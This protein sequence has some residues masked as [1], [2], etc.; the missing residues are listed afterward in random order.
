MKVA[1]WADRHARS[2]LFLLGA[3]VLGGIVGTFALPVS[4]LPRVNFPRIRVNLDAGERPAQR[5]E[6]EVTMPV[7]EAVRAIPGVRGVQSTTSRGSAEVWISFDWGQDMSTALLQAESQVNRVLPTLPSG[8]TFEIIRMDPTVFPVIAYSLTSDTRPLSQL[9]DLA[10]FQLR[11]I[12]SGVTGVAKIG[13]SGGAVEEY[14]VIVDPAKLQAHHLVVSDLSA[15][16][17]AANVLTAAGRVEDHFKLYLVVTDTRFKSLDEIGATVIRSGAGG[18]VLLSDVASVRQTVA[19]QFTRATSDGRD[20]VLMNV[21][22]Q[23]GGNTV[24]IARGIRN[25]LTI[26]QKRLPADVRISSWY[27]QSDLITASARSV[28][29]AVLIGV[30]LAAL[31]LLLFLRNLRITLI[32]AITVPIVLSITALL[33]YLLDQSFNIMT[34]G[35]MAAAV[36]LIID[37]AIVMSEHIVR[38]LHGS[39]ADAKNR[40]LDATDEFTRPLAGS[41]L[42]T[43]I[44]HIPPAFLIGVT[45]AFF[46]ALSLSM[47]ASLIISFLV[48]WLIIPV[49][50]ARVL[51]ATSG[52]APDAEIGKRAEQVDRENRARHRDESL[53]V[54]TGKQTEQVGAENLV[55]DRDQPLAA[56]AKSAEGVDPENRLRHRDKTRPSATSS[57]ASLMRPVLAHP[58]VV[59]LLILPLLA[60]G[61]LAFNRIPSGFMPEVDEGGFVLDYVGPP[62]TSLTETDRILR[63]VEVILR[64]TPEVQTYSRRTGFALGGDIM[65]ANTGDFFIRLKPFPRRPIA[66][67]MDD[68]RSQVEHSLPGL[69]VELAQLMEDLIGDLTGK[70]EPVVI[71]IYSDDEEQLAGL[72]PKVAEA[73]GKVPN[74]V[75]VRNGMVPAGDALNV[76]VDRIKASLEGVDPDSVTKSLTDLLSGSVTTQLQR[77]P[78]LIDLRVWIPKDMRTTIRDVGELNLRAADGHLFPLKRVAT[79]TAITGQPEIT[80]D[81]LKRVVAI[82]GRISGR[83]LGSTIRDVRKV[84][85]DPATLPAGV[86]YTL[87]GLYEQQQIAFKGMLRVIAAAG[88][89]VFLLLLF[90]YESFR[91]TVA[92]M[93]TT[94][95]AIAVV[96]GGLWLTN[97]ELNVSSMMGIVMILG[98]VTE[99]A[100][101]YYSEYAA[102]PAQVGAKGATEGLITAGLFRMRAIT[103]TSVAAVLALLPLALGIGQGSAMLQPLAIAIMAGLIAQLPLVL[104]VLPSLL[105]LFGVPRHRALSVP[106]KTD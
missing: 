51:H 72:A 69:E 4:L 22:Q 76:E 71:N 50:A 8:T 41:S 79:L 24:D 30:G 95:T 100:I 29:D 27:D 105:A 49:L 15:A 74:V 16:L 19:P 84:L 10:E 75:D 39:G 23:P 64:K 7:E 99:V 36:G 55:H 106:Q 94:L 88:A 37:D 85:D 91:V 5:M 53:V 43:I 90:L 17:S 28:L 40:V 3:L 101:F 48:A 102:L 96:F 66:E 12:L 68:V 31:V 34:L 46:A 32:A 86:R 59:V 54:E 98:N 9:R 97:T 77:G 87:G 82:T 92:I 26:E 60:L 35:G 25:A 63:Q 42:S 57:Y 80:R 44:I 65:E 6:A 67:V 104:I 38:R 2:M 83:D 52:H 73:V 93:I 62:G 14:Q 58:W 1:S 89:L 81:N 70:P 47:A 11:P 21:Y 78:K 45:G 103:M 13:V 61:Y 33:L 20:A 56:S 18:V